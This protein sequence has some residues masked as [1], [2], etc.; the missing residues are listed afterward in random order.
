MTPYYVIATSN[1]NL[2]KGPSESFEVVERIPLGYSLKV[3]QSVKDGGGVTWHK[4]DLNEGW[5]KSTYVLQPNQITNKPLRRTE[6]FNKRRNVA[7]GEAIGSVGATTKGGIGTMA[8]RIASAAGVNLGVLGSLA[9]IGQNSGQDMM[10]KRRIYGTPFQFLGTTDMRPDDNSPLGIAFTT[11]IMCETPIL[12][13]LPGIPDYLSEMDTEDKKK[14][15]KKLVDKIN[16]AWPKMKDAEGGLLSEEGRDMKFFEFES[17][18]ADYMLYVNTLCRM[19]ALFMGIGDREVP[20]TGKK[21]S[22]YNWFYYHLS[23]VYKNSD[24][25]PGDAPSAIWDILKSGVKGIGSAVS[26]T[27]NG[28]LAG[29]GLG[30]NEKG[31]AGQANIDKTDNGTNATGTGTNGINN[32]Y[33]DN[34]FDIDTFYM[35]FFVKPP[36][37]SESFSNTTNTSAFAN[38]LQG[39]SGTMREFMFLFGGLGVD[40]KLMTEN[41]TAV[42]ENMK[43]FIDS[44]LQNAGMKKALNSLITGSASV[45]TGANLIFPEIWETSSYNRDFNLEIVLSSP[46]GDKFSIYLNIIV[47]LMHLLAF[48]LPRQATV[49]SYTSPF[50]VRCSLPG[51]FSCDMGIVKELSIS[52]GGSDGT[53]W[54]VDGFPTEVVVNISISDLYN[55]LSMSNLHTTKNVWNFLYNTPLIDYVGSM[56][57][58]NMRS[59][60]WEKKIEMI[61]ALTSN[62]IKDQIDHMK[63]S[64]REW[65]ASTKIKIL[66]GKG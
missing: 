27:V 43:A 59:S 58:L 3:L 41:A 36:S 30:G 64:G 6:Q 32:A 35:N 45:I 29:L 55:S 37:Y 42:T 62:A 48:T 1:V 50:L 5:V 16:D 21:C 65:A 15:T 4:T 63:T 52:K 7:E 22:E 60:E 19:A 26:N 10:M 44:A 66:S 53:S 9:G 33:S 46:Y 11:N 23:N 49:N 28:A 40:A 12:S 17:R 56:C 38:A 25:T 2:R 61:T 20:G 14:M 47:P 54:S 24:F 31:G 51:Y 57:G 39:A 8:A 18:C 13:L 34:Y